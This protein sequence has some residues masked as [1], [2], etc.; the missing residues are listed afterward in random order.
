MLFNLNKCAVIHFGFANEGM[1][2]RLSDKVLGV[3]KSERDLGVINQSDLKMDKQCSK[4]VN[5]S[6]FS[7]YNTLQPHYCMV[8]YSMN[9]V[10]TRLRLGSHCLY[11]LC[12]RP[13]L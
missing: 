2:V 4:A 11:F 7:L 5:V 13:F 3:Q 6:L 10:I 12:I 9:S 8:V 1:E